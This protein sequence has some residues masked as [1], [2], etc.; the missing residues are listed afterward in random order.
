MD[1]HDFLYRKRIHAEA[2]QQARSGEYDDLAA[3]YQAVGVKSFDQQ[4]KFI[5]N[6]LRKI[7]PLPEALV[8]APS[9]KASGSAHPSAD[10]LGTDSQTAPRDGF[11]FPPE[12]SPK[13]A[14]LQ[15]KRHLPLNKKR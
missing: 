14:P 15:L 4:K 8:I 9:S 12:S 13:A 6:P 1:F 10:S 11:P 3:L 7:F 5:F 2:F